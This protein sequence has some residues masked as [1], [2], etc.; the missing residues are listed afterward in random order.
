MAGD[1]SPLH[2]QGWLNAWDV[3]EASERSAVLSY[4]HEG[5]EW[6]WAY[7][8]R[9]A[10]VIDESGLSVRLTCRNRS[11]EPMPC[12][13]G[14]HPYFP[15]GPQTQLDTR[16]DNTWTVDKQVLPV[17][18]IPAEGP[19]D[20]KNR[21]ICRQNLDNGF[22]GWGGKA[23][24]SDPD[25]PFEICLS[26][27]D[28]RFFQ[29]YSPLHGG[30]FAA[31]PVGHANAALNEREAEWPELGLCVLEPGEGTGLDMRIDVITDGKRSG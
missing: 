19:Y 22:G 27:G 16:V 21:Q 26:S 17:E 28:A 2:G 4:R 5:G 1:P 29:V 30:F 11:A 23:R 24:I 14:Q 9:Q 31:E 18:K 10:F 6:P 25:W 8:A 15:C 20:L 12:G 3:E 7:E 13:L